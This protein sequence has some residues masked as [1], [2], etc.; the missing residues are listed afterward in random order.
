MQTKFG[1]NW[2]FLG[3][4]LKVNCMWDAFDFDGFDNYV[5]LGGG[6]DYSIHGIEFTE[7]SHG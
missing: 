1:T 5:H 2:S 3:L 4:P 7:L 6:F